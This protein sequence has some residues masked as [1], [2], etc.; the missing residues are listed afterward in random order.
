MKGSFLGPGGS[1]LLFSAVGFLSCLINDKVNKSVRKTK[2][3][4]EIIATV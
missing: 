3:V 1:S 2:T 4:K